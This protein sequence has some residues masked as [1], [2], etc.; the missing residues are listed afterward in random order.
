M[1][2]RPT[3]TRHDVHAIAERQSK[4]GHTP[5]AA[6]VRS[7]LK[8]GSFTT[9]QAHL[10]DW[11]ATTPQ[12]QEDAPAPVTELALH[13]AKELWAQATAQ[14]NETLAAERAVLEADKAALVKWADAETHKAEVTREHNEKLEARLEEV[15]KAWHDSQQRLAVSEALCQQREQERD[16]AREALDTL[17]SEAKETQ[18]QWDECESHNQELQ[19]EFDATHARWENTAEENRL[20][21]QEI[22]V[23][24]TQLN[25][26]KQELGTT[27]S[28]VELQ[29]RNVQE[30]NEQIKHLKTVYER[31]QKQLDTIT[32]EH[33]TLQA[34]LA[35]TCSERDAAIL[36]LAKMDESHVAAETRVTELQTQLADLT[37]DAE[38]H[39]LAAREWETNYHEQHGQL[40]AL[41]EELR[42]TQRQL[43]RQDLGHDDA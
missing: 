8:K 27:T 32:A 5:T 33:R 26:S 28:K 24:N 3:I 37:V 34:T 42:H 40:A 13:V 41:K 29:S 36:N 17:Q 30:L 2:K 6:S 23:L 25:D 20:Q 10:D 18:R 1:G 7:E 31:A 9:I 16:V 4:A 43:Y 35:D 11:R 39:Q 15:Q 22:E 12:A 21:K 19:R 38:A 14:A